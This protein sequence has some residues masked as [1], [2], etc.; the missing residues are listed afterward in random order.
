[1]KRRR[2]RPLTFGV[3]RLIS[4]FSCLVFV[5][6]VDLTV[7]LDEITEAFPFFPRLHALFAHK[8][9]AIPPAI[10][11]GVGPNG[12]EVL[13]YQPPTAEP[14]AANAIAHQRNMQYQYITMQQALVEHPRHPPPFTP[15]ALDAAAAADPC[16]R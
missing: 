1:M 10:A 9:N 11:T 4:V 15:P 12:P 13:Y 16:H 8:P 14:V 2:R 7:E 6:R 3:R 5:L